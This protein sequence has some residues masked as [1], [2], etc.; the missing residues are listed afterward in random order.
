MGRGVVFHIP[1]MAASDWSNAGAVI[2]SV[3]VKKNHGLQLPD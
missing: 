2:M 1:E 3:R